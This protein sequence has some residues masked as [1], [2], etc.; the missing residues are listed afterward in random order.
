MGGT[1]SRNLAVK[2][3]TRGQRSRSFSVH[4]AIR[5]LHVPVLRGD[6]LGYFV[7]HKNMWGVATNHYLYVPV[8][9]G[10]LARLLCQAQEHVG[11]GYEFC[12]H[13]RTSLRVEMS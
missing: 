12:T 5:Y 11:R 7:R 6:W 8:R 9:R 13:A 2:G 3:L 4:S 10:G 1:L